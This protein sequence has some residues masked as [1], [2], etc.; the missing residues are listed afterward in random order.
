MAENKN[1]SKKDKYQE[2]LK[3]YQA[4]M[5]VFRDGDFS[6][7][8]QMFD[9]F[10]KNYDEERELVDR[11]QIYR[12]ICQGRLRKE[13]IKLETF[14]DY[15]HYSVIQA[16]RGNYEEAIKNL[17]KAKELKPDDGRVYYLMAD[18]FCLMNKTDECL[19]SLKKA[20]QLDKFYGILAQNEKDFEPLWED[21]KFKLIIRLA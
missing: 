2:S 16:N 8:A 7:A 18:T 19:N 13:E 20:V 17:E 3:A 15:Y 4:V 10:I 9:S 14:D 11:A 21:K 1:L 12:D 6:K 5:K